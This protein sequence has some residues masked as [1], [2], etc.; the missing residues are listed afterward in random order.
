MAATSFTALALLNLVQAWTHKKASLD[1]SRPLDCGRSTLTD[2][3]VVIH[4]WSDRGIDE[5]CQSYHTHAFS[6]MKMFKY[7][8]NVGA[9]AGNMILT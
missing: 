2:L 7:I 1:S 8:L 3:G 4:S 6:S 9:R 5:A